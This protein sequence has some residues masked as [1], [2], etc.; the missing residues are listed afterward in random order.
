MYI[1]CHGDWQDE[2]FA[3]CSICLFSY[4]LCIVVVLTWGRLWWL[5]KTSVE[6]LINILTWET[7]YN[8]LLWWCDCNL[9]SNGI[10]LLTHQICLWT[11]QT[12]SHRTK[13]L[14]CYWAFEGQVK[15]TGARMVNSFHHHWEE[16]D[17]EIKYILAG[18]NVILFDKG[19][20]STYTSIYNAS[21]SWGHEGGFLS[22]M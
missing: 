10:C 14:F 2:Q 7:Y 21:R 17:T 3:R 12:K 16:P 19:M 18:C 9:L 4:S 13:H 5:G 20:I 1:K 11:K 6:S 15:L 22:W 8:L